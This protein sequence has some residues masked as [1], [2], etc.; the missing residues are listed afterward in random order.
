VRGVRGREGRGA[1]GARGVVGR[2]HRQCELSNVYVFKQFQADRKQ[3]V[4]SS[5]VAVAPR[6]GGGGGVVAVVVV[7]GAERGRGAAT[8]RVSVRIDNVA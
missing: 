8:S 7:R 6:R 2:Q 5:C 4:L 1:R 3:Y